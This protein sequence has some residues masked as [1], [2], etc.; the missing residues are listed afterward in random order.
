M[1]QLFFNHPLGRTI[2]IFSLICTIIL[3]LAILLAPLLVPIILSFALY[4]LLEPL[5]E[6]L[7]RHGL[8][9]SASSLSVLLILVAVAAL[10]FSVLLPHLAKQLSTLQSQLPSVWQSM[11]SMGNDVS[12]HLFNSLDLDINT[13]SITQHF[14]TQANDWGTTAL[15]QGSNILISLMIFLILVP[16][17]TFFLVRDYR[18]FRN[19]MLDKLPNSNFEMGW[20]IYHR[21][22]HQLQEY[23]RGIMIQ[24]GIMC[25]MTSIGFYIIG[26]DSPF[27]LG[28]TAGVLNL[29]PYVGPLLATVLPILLAVSKVPIELWLIGAAISVILI[30]QLID[31]MIVIPSVIANAVNLHP[32]IV[33]IG[34]IVF[35]NL[36]GFIGMVVATPTL[37]TANIIYRGLYKGIKTRCDLKA[38]S[39]AEY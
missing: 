36:F 39:A 32:L 8:S 33:I 34:I 17:I 35:G 16:I 30:A 5:S 26:L 25:V 6:I 3:L 1:I 31:S 38:E 23:I 9:R 10:V 15:I 29:I 2:T 24:S 18:S 27:L 12:Q 19:Y 21:V 28:A 13:S 22:A 37:S 14:F 11:M 7:E 4:A 20:L